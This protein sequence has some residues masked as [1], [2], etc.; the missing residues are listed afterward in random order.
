MKVYYNPQAIGEIKGTYLV[1]DTNI[2]G[3]YSS[4]VDF[5][6]TFNDIFKDNIIL[7]DPIVKLEF[8]RGAFREQTYKEKSKFLEYEKFSIMI[9]HQEI[10]RKAYENAFNIARIYSHNGKS[11]IPLGDIL[12]I[13][14]L[15]SYKE[16]CLFITLDKNDFSTLLFDRIAILTFERK[17]KTEILE[18]IQLLRFNQSKYNKHLSSLPN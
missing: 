14:R 17:V 12:I 16:N 11:N 3:S 1:F 8:L 7:I 4:D 2:L 10:Y 15:A 6:K 18:H 9:D 5:F 13:S